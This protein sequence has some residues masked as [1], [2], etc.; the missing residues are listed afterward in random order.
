[1]NVTNGTECDSTAGLETM[2]QPFAC[3]IGAE[4]LLN[5]QNG[6][7]GNPLALKFALVTDPI[8]EQQFILLH[9][10]DRMVNQLPFLG[11][12]VQRPRTDLGENQAR[13]LENDQMPIAGNA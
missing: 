9:G 8:P 2:D 1:M 13:V 4:L 3:R 10:I 12:R 5:G 7:Q 6:L 11:Q